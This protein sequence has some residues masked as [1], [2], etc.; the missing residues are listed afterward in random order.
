MKTVKNVS[1][2]EIRRVREREA[3]GLVERNWVYVKKSLWKAAK[4]AG[5]NK[6]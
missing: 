1:T 4:R 5:G 6:G 3:A 2:G